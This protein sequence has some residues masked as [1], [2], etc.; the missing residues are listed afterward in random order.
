MV[1]H[2]GSIQERVVTKCLNTRYIN[3]NRVLH[4]GV[5]EQAGG[6]EQHSITETAPNELKI[7]EG[8]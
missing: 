7:G 5:L 6:A 8:R 4:E 2:L 3:D 1:E